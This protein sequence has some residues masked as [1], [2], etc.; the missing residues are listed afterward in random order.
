MYVCMYVCINLEV[1][2]LRPTR[3]VAALPHWP[4]RYEH[5]GGTPLSMDVPRVAW[6]ATWG[7]VCIDIYIYIVCVLSV[8]SIAAKARRLFLSA[9]P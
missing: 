2:D 1:H 9:W 8:H 7:H 3:I 6:S 5:R 4:P